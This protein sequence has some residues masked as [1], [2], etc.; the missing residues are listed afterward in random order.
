[1]TGKSK[2]SKLSLKTNKD[3]AK[4]TQTILDMFK[5]QTSKSNISYKIETTQ[6]SEVIVLEDDPVP[7]CLDKNSDGSESQDVSSIKSEIDYNVKKVDEPNNCLTSNDGCKDVEKIIDHPNKKPK[8]E[9]FSN[10]IDN[11]SK[12][13]KGDSLVIDCKPN[14]DKDQKAKSNG[15]LSSNSKVVTTYNG[16]QKSILGK[17]SQEVSESGDL[18]TSRK[19]SKLVSLKDGAVS[20]ERDSRVSGCD[21][22]LIDFHESIDDCIE[23]TASKSSK[24][25]NSDENDVDNNSDVGPSYKTPYYLNNFKTV[26]ESVFEDETNLDLFNNEDK[27]IIE[28]FK[29]LSGNLFFLNV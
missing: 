4:K 1:M 5:R 28:T 15:T 29:A 16:K 21:T 26:L 7:S 3:G 23:N 17:R 24:V 6:D 19:R 25:I 12:L 2:K 10:D 20:D 8:I 18:E 9:Q 27:E 22:N 13:S 11:S 14:E